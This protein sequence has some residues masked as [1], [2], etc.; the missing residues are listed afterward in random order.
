MRA[1]EDNSPGMGSGGS[2]NLPGGIHSSPGDNKFGRKSIM[3][4]GIGGSTGGGIGRNS[5]Y[6]N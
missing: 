5:V 6:G 2:L 4:R 3:G 1:T